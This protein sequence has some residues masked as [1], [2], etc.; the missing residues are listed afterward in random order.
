MR[1]LSVNIDHVATLRQARRTTY[2]SLATA[3]GICEVAGADGI[4]LHLREDRRHIQDEDLKVLSEISL[5]PLT[6]EMAPTEEMLGI[7]LQYRPRA[8][9]LVPENRLE[10]TTEG[11]IDA[12]RSASSLKPVLQALKEAGIRT[13]LF[14]EPD[15]GQIEQARTLQA[16]SVELHTGRYA[17]LF[18]VQKHLPELQRIDEA[19]KLG[20]SLGLQ[21]NAGHGLHYRNIRPLAALSGLQEFSI[22]HSIVSRSI[23]VGLE[24]AVREMAE[25]VRT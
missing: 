24:R 3:A 15:P 14:L 20:R 17:E 19:V 6:L 18:D 12:I 2:P 16:D 5:L 22:G 7:A 11:G 1:A 13:C 25:L 9:T 21:M 23:F 10:I 4:T 8:V